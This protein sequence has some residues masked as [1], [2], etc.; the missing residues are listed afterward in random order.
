VNAGPPFADSAPS[1]RPWKP[2]S[3][4]TTFDRPVAARPILIAASI[5]SAP[6]FV[7]RTRPSLV[8]RR[9]H[10]LVVAAHVVHPEAAEHVEEAVALV[11]EQVGALAAGPAAVEADRPQHA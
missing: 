6:E 1:V 7:N 10:A 8:Q 9:P 5:D 2:C 3:T 4:E 11:V